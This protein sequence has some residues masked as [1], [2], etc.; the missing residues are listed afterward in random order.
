MKRTILAAGLGAALM[1]LPYLAEAH[2]AFNAEYD[3]SKP[4]TLVGPITKVDQQNPHGWIYMTVEP[5]TPTGRAITWQLETPGPNQLINNGFTKA[6]YEEMVAKNE[7][8]TV[9]AYPAKDGSKHAFAE[10]LTRADNRTV[11]AISTG[12][13]T[14]NVGRAAPAN[15]LVKVDG[16]AVDTG[17]GRGGAGGG[18]P[19]GGAGGGA[20]RGGAPRGPGGAG[21]N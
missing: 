13:V 16:V 1:T 3:G 15:E 5:N 11:I 19:R 9:K 6:M 7:R 17:G 20:P 12:G 2:H 14:G 21:G 8:V 4:L 18:A 10:S